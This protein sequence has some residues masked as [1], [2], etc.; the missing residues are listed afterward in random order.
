[1]SPLTPLEGFACKKTSIGS[2][3]HG[4]PYVIKDNENG[5]LFENEN[6]DD[7]QKKMKELLLDPAKCQKLGI[8]GYEMIKKKFNNVLMGEKIFETYNSVLNLKSDT[9]NKET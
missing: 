1:M 2:K 3:I 8:K 6:I 7:L 4:I 9:D 5:L